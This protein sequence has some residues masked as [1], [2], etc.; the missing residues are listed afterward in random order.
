M[1]ATASTRLAVR[2]DEER[3]DLSVHSLEL[4][5]ALPLADAYTVLSA[6]NA[7]LSTIADTKKAA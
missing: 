3:M 2:V 6:L 4:A 1:V 7:L 5:R